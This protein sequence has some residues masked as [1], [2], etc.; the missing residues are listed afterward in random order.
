MESGI[1]M[2]DHSDWSGGFS[3][4]CFS[5]LLF[6][7]HHKLL[8]I[9]SLG[10]ILHPAS[11]AAFHSTTTPYMMMKNISEE[12]VIKWKVTLLFNFRF[13]FLFLFRWNYDP[14]Y[15]TNP[16]QRSVVSITPPLFTHCS[17][18][19]RNSTST[20]YSRRWH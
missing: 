5:L 20:I 16:D 9:G 3:P 4:R 18:H 6:C 15:P 10:C 7:L 17:F 1:T 11:L 12:H 8:R 13:L 2:T 14:C 19:R